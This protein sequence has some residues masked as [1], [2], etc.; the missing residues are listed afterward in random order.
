MIDAREALKLGYGH[1]TVCRAERQEEGRG[2][3][4]GRRWEN[5]ASSIMFTI[6]LERARV[7][8]DYPL[9]QLLAHAL[10]CYLED[11][12]GLEPQIKWPNDVLVNGA[13]IAGILVE[14][15]GEYFLGGMGINIDFGSGQ[16]E[17]SAKAAGLSE[18]TKHLPP[19]E[20]ILTDI[21][22]Q[23]ERALDS[24]PSIDALVKRLAY[25]GKMVKVHLGDP[26]GK[27][28]VKGRISGMNRHGALLLDCGEKEMF[29]VYSGEI[30]F[31]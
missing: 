22:H 14:T 27:S 13:K 23:I 6:V 20:D 4:P 26:A 25:S 15:E 21:L 16:Q 2:R 3:L 10:C 29:A 31:A 1:G 17:F 7:G 30:E 8:I 19:K 24:R 12:Y 28:S 11:T 9:T 18:L 5:T